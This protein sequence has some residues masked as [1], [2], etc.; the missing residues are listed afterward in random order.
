MGSR[1]KDAIIGYND[2]CAKHLLQEADFERFMHYSRAV[3]YY[4]LLWTRDEIPGGDLLKNGKASLKTLEPLIGPDLQ[5]QQT[6]VASLRELYSQLEGF[7]NSAA[8]LGSSAAL[9]W[10]TFRA[11]QQLHQKLAILR[12]EASA[13]LAVMDD[14]K[15]K[16]SSMSTHLP[17]NL[18]DTAIEQSCSAYDRLNKIIGETALIDTL[19][20][21]IPDLEMS[22]NA[23]LAATGAFEQTQVGPGKEQEEQEWDLLA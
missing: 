7:S 5:K 14:F 16:S 17:A 8:R 3:T 21:K 11:G 1:L 13:M 12:D 6:G 22:Q 23:V 4:A 15:A 2:A 20:D 18:L 10:Q 9:M 19:H